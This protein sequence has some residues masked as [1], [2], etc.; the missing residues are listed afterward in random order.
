MKKYV[1]LLILCL[2]GM[3]NGCSKADLPQQPFCR[4]VTQIHVTAAHDGT[5][6]HHIYTDSEKM[7]TML[8]YLRQLSPDAAA[9]IDPDTFRS[10]VFQITVSY[11]DGNQA[12]YYQIYND[13]FKEGSGSWQKVDA[14]QGASLYPILCSMASDR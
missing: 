14:D 2:C 13:L 6:S 8:N 4:V 11:S 5:V 7:E 3:L 10:D 9:N 12:T 1:F